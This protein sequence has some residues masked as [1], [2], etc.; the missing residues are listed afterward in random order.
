MFVTDICAGLTLYNFAIIIFFS[1]CHSWLFFF[2]ILSHIFVGSMFHIRHFDLTR[3]C[4]S[5]PDKFSFQQVV[6]DAIQPPLLRSKPSF[7]FTSITTLL[8]TYPASLL[9][10][11][12]TGPSGSNDTT[13]FT[14]KVHAF[15][16]SS[17]SLF[18]CILTISHSLA[19]H[20]VQECLHAGQPDQFTRGPH[21]QHDRGAST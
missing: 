18:K 5:S 4:A 12:H 2:R 3:S 13:S 20:I 11:I 15:V 21:S 7:F 16:T 19:W 8:P 1:E 10:F 17:S 14:R 6:L 9:M